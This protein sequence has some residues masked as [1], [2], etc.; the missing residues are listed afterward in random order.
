MAQEMPAF[1]DVYW[2][3]CAGHIAKGGLAELALLL[4][5]AGSVSP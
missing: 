1:L 5:E 4:D 2:K 3:R